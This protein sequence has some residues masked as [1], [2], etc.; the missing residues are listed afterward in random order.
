LILVADDD[1]AVRSITQQ[2]LESFGYRV[3]TANDGS[4]ALSLF[5][6][7]QAEIALVIT[8]LMMPVMD[9]IATIQVLKRIAPDVKVIAGSGLVTDLT[10][11][12][13]AALGV[14]QVL[15]KPYST[16]AVLAALQKA[17]RNGPSSE[18]GCPAPAR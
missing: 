2:V 3:I 5:V 9:G 17:L 8:D 15:L 10:S 1:A 6:Q 16:E 13:M 4:E 14:A 18:D 12:Q 7:H 11:D